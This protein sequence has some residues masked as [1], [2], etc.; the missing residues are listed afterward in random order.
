MV[1]LLQIFEKKQIE[2]LT[3][4]K[5]IPAFRSGDVLKVTLKIIEGERSRTQIFEGM[6]IARK[7]NGVNSKFT[8]R[9][10]SHGEG[11]ERVFPL[12]SPIIDKIEVSTKGDVNRAK[13]YYLRN[14]SG[15]KARISLRDRG[16]EADQYEF[17]E[18]LEE[19]KEVDE[20]SAEDTIANKESNHKKDI[21]E[22]S[23]ETIN[24][25]KAEEVVAEENKSSEGKSETSALEADK[26]EDE[27]KK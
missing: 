18:V 20:T 9:K 7:N 14:R 23:N 13:L 26:T 1:N 16:E 19:K 6:C 11:V 4:N 24:P 25:A 22:V 10:L 17:V 12:F 3:S 21:Q 27:S 8:V 5:R 2:K 15:K